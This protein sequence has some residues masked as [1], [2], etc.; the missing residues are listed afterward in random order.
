VNS[1]QGRVLMKLSQYKN[2]IKSNNKNNN[3]DE[4]GKTDKSRK[5]V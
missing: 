2:N 4:V 1:H 5:K 3:I